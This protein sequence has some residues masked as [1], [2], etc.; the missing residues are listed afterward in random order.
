MPLHQTPDP[1]VIDPIE[2]KDL[3]ARLGQLVD[4]PSP[5]GVVMRVL[6][7]GQDPEVSLAEVA[8]VIGLDP[9]LTTKL[10]R[11]ANSPLYA[12][13]RKTDNLRQAI[14]L[15]GLEGTIT[16]ALGFSMVSDLNRKQ[17]GHF[18]YQAYWRRSLAAATCAQVLAE[19][20]A[21][22]NREDMFLA[23]LL[24]D[25]GMMALDRAMPELYRDM[26]SRLIHDR[27]EAAERDALGVDH[28]AVGAWL[29]KQWNFPEHLQLLVQC[30]HNPRAVNLSAMPALEQQ[31]RIIAVS[32]VMADLWTHVDNE[33]L[34]PKAMKDAEQ[35][36]G[37]RDQSFV[38]IL[39]T[40]TAAIT[41]LSHLFDVEFD[42]QRPPEMII[43]QARELILLRHIKVMQKSMML[44][45]AARILENR[46]MRLEE[47]NRRDVLTGLFNRSYLQQALV[48]E[49]DVS[50]Q[51]GWPFAVIFADLDRFKTINDEHGHLAGDQIIKSTARILRQHTRENDIVARY[52]GEEFVV[53][54]PGA[55]H[56]CAHSTCERLLSA[57]RGMRHRVNGNVDLTVTASMGVAVHG[58]HTRF[59]HLEDILRAADEALY[60]AKGQGRD[61][62]VFHRGD[63]DTSMLAG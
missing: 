56:D 33:A 5:A 28:A 24:Q 25:V 6:E 22:A 48:D 12:R 21:Q 20:L 46:T 11:M 49:L 61:C 54:L 51:H 32:S 23:G 63:L 35:Q 45:K 39:E 34:M 44:E 57:F 27:L 14:T 40:A 37:I 59:Q 3:L 50:D 4:L 55:G 43:N 62:F 18:D 19:R 31:A 2:N 53:L 58:E 26:P 41:E 42:D 8:K 16:L 9:A 36:L 52:G 47:E 10:L 60:E 38:E 17:S 15:F 13:K 7:L 1:T 29:L 30:S